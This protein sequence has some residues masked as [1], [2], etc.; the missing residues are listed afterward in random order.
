ME[1]RQLAALVAVADAGSVTAAA[2]VLRMVQPAVTRQI[3]TLEQ[4]VGV[5]LFTRTRQGMVLTAE[6]ELLVDRARRALGELERARLEISPARDEVTG[7]VSVGL[8]ESVADMLTEPL[9]ASVARAYPGIELRILTAYSGHLRQWLDAGDI[10]M[11]LIYNLSP[12][13]SLAVMPLLREKLWAA[14][15]P[16]ADLS[17]QAPVSW[18]ELLEHPLV[19]PVPGHGLRALIDLALSR[20]SAPPRVAVQVNSMH[21][22]KQLV[23][24]G[25]G[26]TVL[27]A[28]GVA[29]DVATGRLS[30]A[31]LTTPEVERS[32][33][34]GL[35]VGRRTP[36][37]VES[38]ASELGRLAAELTLSGTWPAVLEANP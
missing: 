38:V 7:V 37:A 30:G 34:L 11:S 32:V 5:L 25:R 14:A 24:A 36:L 26:W 33:V 8:L 10:D 16:E 3:R 13:P 28:A 22:Q 4:E 17:G 9:A 31:P 29:S 19:L 27:P 35:R 18:A 2:R 6:G 23:L 20:L 15:P 12:T 21:L 1:I